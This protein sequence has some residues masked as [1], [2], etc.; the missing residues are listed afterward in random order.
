MI[1]A[2]MAVAAVSVHLQHGFFAHEQGYE[3]TLTLAIAALSV[4]FSGPGAFSIDAVLGDRF[5][6]PAWGV[7]ALV[8]G[9]AGAALQ[10]ARRKVP[11]VQES[12]Q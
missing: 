5:A 8:F 3:Y 1:I 11:A 7:A 9:L 10:L 4:A 2:V 12:S 6:G